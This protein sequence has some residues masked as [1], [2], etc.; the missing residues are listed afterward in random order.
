VVDP[1]KRI[2]GDVAKRQIVI[3]PKNTIFSIKRLMGRRYSDESI[4]N[5]AKWLPYNIKEG[6]D[7]MA[8]V[9]VSGKTFT[10]QEISAQI[11]QKKKRTPKVTW[12]RRLIKP[13]LP[14]PH[15]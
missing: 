11:L 13:L 8:V 14:F 6:R 15:I 5:D 3:N 1:I 7:Q 12:E 9:E 10:P 2:V 4:K